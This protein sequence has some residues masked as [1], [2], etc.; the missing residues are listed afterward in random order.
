MFGAG[1]LWIRMYCCAIVQMF[2]ISQYSSTP[3]GMFTP[4]NRY[5]NGKTYS[6]IFCCC[7]N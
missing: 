3:T 5:M 2:E 7:A 4:M 1:L 6:M